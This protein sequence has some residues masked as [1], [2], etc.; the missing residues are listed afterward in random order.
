MAMTNSSGHIGK[1]D[2]G[3]RALKPH[4]GALPAWQV[5]L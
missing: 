1:L 3:Q 5:R 2:I 4:I